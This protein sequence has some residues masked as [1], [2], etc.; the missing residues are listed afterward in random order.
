MKT[1][2]PKQKTTKDFF[3][4]CHRAN[5]NTLDSS[6]V[7]TGKTV[8]AVHL[9]MEL[10]IPVAVLCPK[11]VIPSWTRELEAHGIEPVF[12]MNFEK[13]RNGK[14]PW[15]TKVGKKIMRWS[16]VPSD[17]LFLVDEVHKCKGPYT[18]N[19]QLVVSLIQQGFSVHGMSATAAED[20]TEMRALGYLLELHGLNKPVGNLRS[21][22][23]WMMQYG[24]SQDPW[25]NWKMGSRTKMQPL[26]DQMYGVNCSKLTPSDFPDSF[27]ANRV[28]IDPI[29]F[30]DLKKI[31]KAYEQLGITP[32]IIEEYISH[33]TVSNHEHVLVNILKA[34]QLAESFKVPDIHEM[35]RDF[36][37]EG[38]NV[39]V[40]VNFTDTVNALTG[41][42][43]CA[44]IDGNQNAVQRQRV[45]DDFQDD[46]TSCIVVNITAG[47][48]GLSLHDVRG[49][50][51]RISLV[52]PT[53]NAK[54][55]LQVLGRIHRN[56]SRSDAVQKVL[57]AAGTIEEVVMTA[58]KVKIGNL[59]TLHGA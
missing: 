31:D 39:V 57:V 9:A 33:G 45:I 47:G 22:Y 37:D 6:S 4:G 55:Y 3:V 19:A 14:T 41:L 35:A 26:H 12:V 58:I 50:R 29:E 53:F 52:C 15:L 49:D 16:N 51:P 7:G 48:T 23:G 30:K 8:V 46:V 1:L 42:L 5:K 43:K 27:R 11:A 36:I 56:G 38:N 54:D 25:G 21:W 24:C 40:F 28:F 59:E 32:A 34:R 17:T 18:L 44:K 13:V 2:Y 20:P 10:K